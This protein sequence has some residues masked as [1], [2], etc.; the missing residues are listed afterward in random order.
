MVSFDIPEKYRQGRD[1]LRNKLKKIGFRELQKSVF[2]APY[3]C[4]EEILLLVKYFELEKYVRFG[5][6]EYIDNEDY[7]KKIYKIS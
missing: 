2:V 4:K 1:A 5:I 3:N 6:L 7:F